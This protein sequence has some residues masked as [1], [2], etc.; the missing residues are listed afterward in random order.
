MTS[1][2]KL[3]TRRQLVAHLNAEGFPYSLSTLNKLCSVAIGGGPAPFA[4][5]GRRPLYELDAG[6]EW[7]KARLSTKRPPPRGTTATNPT[8]PAQLDLEEAIA[9]LEGINADP[10]TPSSKDKTA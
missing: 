10:D 6:V 9:R 4:W 7:A 5:Q 8:A 2:P 1:K 3:G